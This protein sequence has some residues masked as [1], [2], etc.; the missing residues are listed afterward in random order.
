MGW[1]FRAR[2]RVSSNEGRVFVGRAG[3]G[4]ESIDDEVGKK[5]DGDPM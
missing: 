4:R 2:A 1:V 3:R 5:I